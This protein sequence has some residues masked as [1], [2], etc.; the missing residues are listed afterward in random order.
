MEKPIIAI[1]ISGLL[2]KSDPW[3]KAHIKWFNWASEELK[4]PSIKE[5]SSKDNYFQYVD[6]VMKK[7]FPL[8]SEEKRTIKARELFFDMVCNGIKENTELIN[9]KVIENLRKLKN[10]FKIALITTNNLE[11]VNKITKIAKINDFF[12]II[13]TSNTDEKDDKRLVFERFIS[14]Y[15]KPQL[16]VGGDRKDSYDYCKLNEINCVFANFE[17]KPDI[18]DVN[19]AYNIEELLKIIKK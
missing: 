9:K 4:N 5:Y 3:K 10:Q 11:S 2:I 19:S 18:L 6:E 14:K 1:T 17:Q 16:Y 7:L 8:L 13:E 12:D 15:G